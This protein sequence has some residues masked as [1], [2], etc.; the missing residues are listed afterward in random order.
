M[1]AGGREERLERSTML[2]GSATPGSSSSSSPRSPK[3]IT[4]VP[5]R[6][7][8]PVDSETIDF[9]TQ[10]APV[11]DNYL[12]DDPSTREPTQIQV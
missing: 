10:N 12:Y 3:Q 6:P 9:E 8:V 4:V 5:G 1:Q 11:R 2:R 7:L